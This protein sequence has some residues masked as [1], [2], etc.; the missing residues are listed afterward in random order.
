MGTFRSLPLAATLPTPRTRLIGRE[1]ERAQ[2]RAFLLDEAVPL[3]TLIGPGGVGKTRLAIALAQGVA[4]YFADGVVWVDLSPLTDPA[5]LATTLATALA[6]PSETP[7][8]PRDAVL[9][10]LRPRQTLLVVDNCEHLLAGVA[11]LL[12]HLLAH[13][14]AVQVLATSRAPLHIRGEQLF[15]VAPLAVPQDVAEPYAV[16]TDYAAVQLFAARAAAAQPSF[17]VNPG[18]AATVAALCRA[19]DGLPLAIELTAARMTV[20]SPAALLAQ[21]SVAPGR[22]G[23][24]FRDLPARQQ[25][26]AAAI[27]WSYALLDAEA[28][29]VLRQLAVFAGSFTLDAAQ[30]VADIPDPE[31]LLTTLV[32]QSLVQQVAQDDEARFTLLET[33][34]GYALAQLTAQGEE[35]AARDRHAAWFHDL[36]VRSQAALI[37]PDQSR[38]LSVVDADRDNLRS[39]FAWLLQQGSPECA[40]RM[41]VSLTVYWF[42]R[43]AFAEGQA[44]LRA[45]RSG[46]GL[47]PDLLVTVLDCEAALAHYAGDY[48]HTEHLAQALLA[49]GQQYGDPRSDALG[50]HFM[51]K[52]IGAHSASPAAVEH[53]EH[54]LRYFRAQPNPFDLPLSINRL[55]LELCEIGAYDRAYVLYEEVLGLWREM[56]DTSGALMTLAN[57]GALHWQRGE[58]ARALATFQESLALAWERQGL[59]GCIE[60][61]AGIAAVAADFGW[62]HW[63]ACLLGV[64][65]TLCAQTGYTLYSWN[66]AVYA[67]AVALARAAL[68]DPVVDAVRGEARHAE[69]AQVVAAACSFDTLL[70]PPPLPAPTQPDGPGSAP[71]IALTRREREILDLL[72]ARQTNTEIAG[73][74]FLSPRTVE[75]HVRNILGKLGAENRREAAARA[76]RLQLA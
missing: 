60:A 28:Q 22:P 64:V 35:A 56:G 70:P 17:R 33:I 25:T 20:Q 23:H 63:A 34:R 2:G 30:T 49:H 32:E 42:Q 69:L 40:G 4:E 24:A 58:P 47:S 51:S 9:R 14:P 75:S 72:C 66:R 5:L 59:V 12:A 53:A 48:V 26:M 41:A 1:V 29:R 44:A 50:H 11:A 38:W 3:L 67:H 10:Q 65:D 57:L 74:L 37:G 61:L 16:V 73:H 7:Q 21:M 46:G 76:V 62:H 43:D 31:R 54:A 45:V 15:P 18:N 27:G 39:A 19:L 6:L 13:C 68:G 52:A 55:A 36:A 8:S 71:E